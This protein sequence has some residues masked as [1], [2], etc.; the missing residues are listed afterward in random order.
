MGVFNLK[1]AQQ[2]FE[3]YRNCWEV[4]LS[5]CEGV[6]DRNSSPTN[7]TKTETKCIEVPISGVEIYQQGDMELMKN[8]TLRA[9]GRYMGRKQ[10]NG[11]IVYAYGNTIA[12]VAQKLKK[13][14]KEALKNPKVKKVTYKLFDWLDEWFRAYK[15]N[16][17]KYTSAKDIERVIKIVKEK[18]TN[19]Y[20]CDLTTSDIQ[21]F[22]N[23]YPKSRQKEIISLYFDASLKKAEELGIIEKN[24]FRGVVKDKRQN[25][26]RNGYSLAEQQK[27]LEIIKGESIEKVVIFYLITGIR[28]NE[29]PTIDFETDLDVKSKTLKILSEKKRDNNKK[30]RYIDLSDEAIKFIQ[31]NKPSLKYYPNFVY[32][33]LKKLISPFGIETGLHRLRHTFATN[34]FY[35][36]TPIKLVSS[37]LG[38]EKIEL[39]QNIYTHID[40]SITKE[41][42]IKLYNNLYYKI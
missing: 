2:H 29:L 3:H 24:P 23:T 30:Y 20:L 16:F 4:L 9:D 1:T 32:K 31:D 10:I 19:I 37:W 18:F 13:A 40:R 12:N 21:K 28:K 5:Y 41:D 27:I 38:H 7:E 35:L 8:I 22:L 11:Q 39:T 15:E 33:R 42:I 17:V 25:I 6:R 36:G 14:I 34:H 26:V